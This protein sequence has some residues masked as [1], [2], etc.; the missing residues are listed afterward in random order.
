MRQNRPLAVA[1]R[2]LDLVLG[3]QRSVDS[4]CFGYASEQPF[5]KLEINMRYQG[6]LEF[7]CFLFSDFV[8]LGR[9]EISSFLV[10]HIDHCCGVQSRRA[11]ALDL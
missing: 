2:F 11:S 3:D 6:S 8:H 4:S 9:N 10:G 1:D 7:C 5:E